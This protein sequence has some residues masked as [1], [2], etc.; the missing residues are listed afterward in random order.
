MDD[1]EPEEQETVPF[2]ELTIYAPVDK[3]G[4]IYRVIADVISPLDSIG[5]G[6]EKPLRKTGRHEWTTEQRKAAGDRMR[7]RNAEKKARP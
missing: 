2:V 1:E 6:E 3:I 4:E 5:A 7:A